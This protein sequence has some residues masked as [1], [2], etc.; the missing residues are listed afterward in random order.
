MVIHVYTGNGKGKTTAAVGLAVRA[1]GRGVNVVFA[2]FIKSTPSGELEP[3][4][5]LGVKVIRS[6]MRLGFTF[7]MDAGKKELCR[8]EQRRILDEAVDAVRS[9]NAGLAVL[10]EALDA[11]EAGVLDEESLRAF[12][13]ALPEGCELAVTG[14]PV[15]RWL[16][17]AADYYSEVKKIKHPFDRGVKARDGIEK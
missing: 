11:L 9:G 14:R 8:K 6:G 2:Q 15:P 3:L 17:E 1:A 16:A 13:L 12:I 7:Q 5:R 4:A 10:D